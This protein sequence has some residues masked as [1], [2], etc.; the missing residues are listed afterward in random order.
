MDWRHFQLR[1]ERHC[2]N[3]Q[4]IAEYLNAH[5]KVSHVN[6][7]GLPDDK[8]HALAQKYMKDGRTC[9]VISF[10]LT[11]GRDAAVRF[12][13][14]LKLANHRHARCCFHYHGSSPGQPYTP[15]DER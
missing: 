6:Y 13:D 15:P 5:E 3:A 9:G 12:M 8:Y 10:E 11:G 1:V 7:A 14:S 2:S 4:K